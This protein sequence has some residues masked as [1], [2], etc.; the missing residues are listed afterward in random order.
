MTLSN[1]VNGTA[2]PTVTF[3]PN[4]H[5][6][7]RYNPLLGKHVLVS[8]HRTKRPWKGQTEA[9][10]LTKLPAY[11]PE[12]YL[13]PGN[14]RSGGDRNPKYTETFVFENDF[15]ALLSD[16]LPSMPDIHPSSDSSDSS[17]PTA[18]FFESR[19]VRGRCKVICFHPRHDLTLARMDEEDIVHVVEGWRGI[20]EEEGAMLRSTGGGDEAEGHVQIF[21]NRGAMMG[22]SAPHPHGQVWSLSYVPDEPATTLYHLEKHAQTAPEPPADHPRGP[23]GRPSLLVSYAWEEVKR[24]ERVVEIDEDSGWVAVVP[25]WATWPYEILLLPYKRHISSLCGLTPEETRG[26]AKVLKRV[27]VRFDNLF[28]CPF[29]YS[30]GI[31]QAPLPPLA[32]K[33][34]SSASIHFH[35]YPPLLRSAS[36]RK[37]LVGFEM[38]GEAQ[39]DLTPEQ[40][41][42]KLRSVSDVHY[43]ER[44][45]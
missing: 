8:P 24:K 14:A 7:R 45:Q 33:P 13:C 20:Y 18:S 32:S 11:D 2:H 38:L 22:A 42:E 21:E 5:P 15:P 40:A 23:D 39:R 10:V 25:F 44:Q 3:E 17:N 34:D 28:S 43:L 26:L 41:A 36:V 4:E 9:P 37:F 29:P 16:P 30:M 19:P 1:G 27:L 6:H 35:F 31:H 12:C